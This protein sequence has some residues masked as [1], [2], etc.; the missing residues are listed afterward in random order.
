MGESAVKPATVLVVEDEE[1]VGDLFESVLSRE[2]DVHRAEDGTEAIEM[3]DEDTDVVILDRRMPEMSGDRALEHI[4]SKDIDCRVAMVTGVD[5]DFDVIDMGFD[6]YLVK[7]IDNEKLLETVDRLLA[8]DQYEELHQE[9]SSKIVKRNV[10]E[11]EKSPEELQENDE[12]QRLTEEIEDLEARL[13][14]MKDERDFDERLL[15][16]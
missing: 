6:D 7:P 8:L 14:R 3:V 1:H 9:L 13:E 4:E 16:S 10:I 2:Y 12:F 15:P 5:P 11:V